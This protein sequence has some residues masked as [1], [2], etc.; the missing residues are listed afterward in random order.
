MFP[1]LRSGNEFVSQQSMSRFKGC[2]AEVLG[3]DFVLK[4]GR[5]SYG[6]RMLD[7]G[8]PI[9]LVSTAWATTPWRSPRSTTPTTATRRS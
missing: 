6:Q 5:R 9:E 1:P 8:V 2:V 3:V 4:D 7:R